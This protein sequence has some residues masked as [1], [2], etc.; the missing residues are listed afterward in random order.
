M[1]YSATVPAHR[2]KFSIAVT[3]TVR[4]LVTAF[5][6]AAA[7]MGA[8]LLL[9]IIGTLLYGL[10]GGHQIDMTNAYRHVAIPVAILIGSVALVGS[11]VLEVRARRQR[12][13]R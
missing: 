12:T 10:V 8:G 4:V 9:G 6:F 11:A 2:T 7:G 5:L 3:S 1:T 13:S